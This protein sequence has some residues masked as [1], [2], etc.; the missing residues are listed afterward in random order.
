MGHWEF[1][2]LRPQLGT[3]QYDDGAYLT[4]ADIPG[5]IAGAHQDRGKGNQFLKHIDRTRCL[6]YVVD[7]SGRPD[8]L[9]TKAPWEQLKVLQVRRSRQGRNAYQMCFLSRL[10]FTKDRRPRRLRQD[11]NTQ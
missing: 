6:A 10:L 5:L 3:L 4:L 2:T 9:V 7:L 8:R 11:G 1:T